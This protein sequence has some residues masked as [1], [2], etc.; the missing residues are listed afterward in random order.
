MGA[1]ELDF[2]LNIFNYNSDDSSIILVGSISFGNINFILMLTP[3]EEN[4][5]AKI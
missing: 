1:F 4:L 2:N 3:D 5:N